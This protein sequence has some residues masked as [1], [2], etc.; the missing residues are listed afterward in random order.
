M[1]GISVICVVVHILL[2]VH[3]MDYK[4]FVIE[5]RWINR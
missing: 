5:E 1:S 2:H 3:T 4:G